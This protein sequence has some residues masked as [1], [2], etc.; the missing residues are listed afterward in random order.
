MAHKGTTR[1]LITIFLATL[2]I[3]CV[4]QFIFSF[5]TDFYM[6]LVIVVVLGFTLA[7]T[8]NAAQIVIQNAVVGSMRGRVMSLY[9]LTFRAGPSVGALIIGSLSP[10]TGLPLPV[11]VAAVI[12]LIA[13]I[14]FS[15]PLMARHASFESPAQ[16]P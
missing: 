7:V 5:I 15:R 11:A 13:L 1:G 6:A 2:F 3:T 8:Q 4:D 10:Q 12:A 14:A 16:K 9:G